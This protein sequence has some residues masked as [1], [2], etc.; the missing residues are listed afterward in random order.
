MVENSDN[1]S[2]CQIPFTEARLIYLIDNELDILDFL[3]ELFISLNF[4]VKTF[5]DC[6]EALLNLRNDN[7]DI[8]ISEVKLPKMNGLEF[9][10]YLEVN[11]LKIPIIFMPGILTEEIMLHSNTCKPF[12]IIEKPFDF[13]SLFSTCLSALGYSQKEVNYLMAETINLL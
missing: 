4:K 7:P 8:I 5:C 6:N 13:G 1:N 3:E 9:I 11:E 10:E 2:L 12:A